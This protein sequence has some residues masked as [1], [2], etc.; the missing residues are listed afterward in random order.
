MQF[1]HPRKSFE[2]WTQKVSGIANSWESY[3]VEAASNLQDT[4]THVLVRKQKDEIKNLNDSLVEVNK[5]LET[6][7]YSCLLYTSPSP[8]D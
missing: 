8:R 2:R 6:F 3:D 7:S 5:E 4:I 1:L